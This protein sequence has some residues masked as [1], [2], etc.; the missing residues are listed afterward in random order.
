M[1]ESGAERISVSFSLTAGDY[2]DYTASV[3]RRSRS[4]PA[5]SVTVAIFFCA[6]PVALLFRELAA[7]SVHYRPDAIDAVGEAGLFAFA[8]GVIASWIGSAFIGQIARRRYF[9][10]MES[11]DPRRVEFDHTG[12]TATTRVSAYIWQWTGI[13]G[14]TLERS[15]LLIW[16]SSYSAVVI[17]RRSFDSEAACAAAL[18]FVRARITEANALP[19]PTGEST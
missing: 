4:W 13:H 12:L 10:T 5:F 16:F 3:Q 15:L 8:L 6:I 7:E 14:C 1:S 19:A 11:H 2:A 9:E 17:P 18:A